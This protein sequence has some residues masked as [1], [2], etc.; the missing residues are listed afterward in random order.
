MRAV[1]AWLAILGAAA[2]PWGCSLSN[3]FNCQA[4]DQCNGGTCE[5]EGYCAFPDEECSS[6]RRYGDLAGPLSGKCVPVGGTDTDPTTTAAPSGSGSGSASSSGEATSG[7]TGMTSPLT[8]LTPPD[9]SSTSGAEA[10]STPPQ[11]DTGGPASTSGAPGRC[12]VD[13]FNDGGIGS[14]W[15]VNT[16]PGAS[17]EEQ[18]EGLKIEI[19]FG[20]VASGGLTTAKLLLPAHDALVRVHA[21]ELDD[22]PF[23]GEF[24]L[25]LMDPKENGTAIEYSEG[26]LRAYILLADTWSLEETIAAPELNDLWLQFRF[27]NDQLVYEYFSDGGDP[28][29]LYS[30]PA[31]GADPETA[32]VSFLVGL[33]TAGIGGAE[34]FIDAFEV[35][36]L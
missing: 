31:P 8:T 32:T 35:C 21:I 2:I 7:G 23:R 10:T 15:D 13:N 29:E 20:A 26:E 28:Q 12:F 9:D 33:P 18:P 34:V 27:E 3:T 11:T 24:I 36:P 25:E 14:E 6:G 19:D 30:F 4:D 17:V 1:G 5:A 16:D 22:L